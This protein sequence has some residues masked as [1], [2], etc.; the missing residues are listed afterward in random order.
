MTVEHKGTIL[1]GALGFA[2]GLYTAA[3]RTVAPTVISWFDYPVFP[4]MGSFTWGNVAQTAVLTII[5]TTIGFFTTLLWKKL[6]PGKS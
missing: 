4:G 1:G 6:F 3:E 2:N 5:G